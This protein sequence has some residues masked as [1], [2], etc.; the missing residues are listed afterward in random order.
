MM[1]LQPKDRLR[2][3]ETDYRNR[4]R[5]LAPPNSAGHIANRQVGLLSTYLPGNESVSN[6]RA[7]ERPHMAA[8]CCAVENGDF[9]GIH[10]QQS[11]RRFFTR[12]PSL[13]IRIAADQSWQETWLLTYGS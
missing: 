6:P 4:W 12:S 10:R 8:F 3:I 2:D 5:D 1:A 11:C 7:G 9:S 13:T